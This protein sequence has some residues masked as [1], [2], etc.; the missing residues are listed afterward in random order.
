MTDSEQPP[1][2]NP[3][4]NLYEALGF[5][6]LVDSLDHTEDG[7]I[8]ART[9]LGPEIL[10]QEADGFVVGILYFTANGL[11]VEDLNRLNRQITPGKL[12][13]DDD[14]DVVSLHTIPYQ[15]ERALTIVD[16][17]VKYIIANMAS[18]MRAS[19]EE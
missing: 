9:S 2:H 15:P 4:Q 13:M 1:G 3:M 7:A 8:K 17:L 18:A 5:V 14:G 16:E 6:G 12:T 10:I 19:S 11:T